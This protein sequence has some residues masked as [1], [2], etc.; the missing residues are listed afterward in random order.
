MKRIPDIHR[1]LSRTMD[2][3]N[4]FHLISPDQ[5]IRFGTDQTRG[6]DRAVSS[7]RKFDKRFLVADNKNNR[8]LEFDSDGQL[9]RGFGSVRASDEDFY[10]LTSVYN[11]SQGQLTIVLSKGIDRE[12]VDLTKISIFIRTTELILDEEDS[13]V[14]SKSDDR[15][16]TVQ[17]SSNKINQLIG[18]DSDVTVNFTSG[19]FAEEIALK[20]NATALIGSLGIEVFVGD[21]TYVDH[22]RTLILQAYYPI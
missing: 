13:I 16:L 14:E 10:P 22:I 17:L 12:S 4:H 8:V 1:T 3:G 21:F 5:A 11:P 18:I 6:F 2:T 15:I 7:I 9:I 20:D 19:A